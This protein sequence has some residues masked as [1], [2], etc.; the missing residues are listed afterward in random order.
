MSSQSSV[1]NSRRR[2]RRA[3]A[4][5][6]LACLIVPV[7]IRSAAVAEAIPNCGQGQG[8][9]TGPGTCSVGNHVFIDANN[10]GVFETG[11]LGLA[12][13]P[14]HL[15]N[16]NVYTGK[17]TVT[18]AN[19]IYG[20]FDL[21]SSTSY[22]V[23]VDIPTGYRGSNGSGDLTPGQDDTTAPDPNNYLDNDDNG[24]ISSPAGRL[25]SG[26][27]DLSGQINSNGRVDF[28]LY[29]PG[30]T[31]GNHVFI[32]AN[33]SGVYEA[34]EQG[35]ANTPVHLRNNNA[36]TGKS[37]VTNANGIYSFFD[38]SASDSYQVCVDIPT[39]YRGSNGSGSLAPGQDDTTA[40]DPNNYVDNDDNGRISNPAGRL[41]SGYVILSGGVASNGR[42]DFGL[43]IPSTTTTLATTTTAVRSA[44]TTTTT[45]KTSETTT[46]APFTP[47]VIQLVPP[48]IVLTT[49][50]SSPT[51]TAPAPTTTANVTVATKQNVQV[52]G[53][54]VV[55][56]APP[57]EAVETI[58][59]ALTGRNSSMLGLYSAIFL[60]SGLILVALARMNRKQIN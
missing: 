6:F 4:A 47:P 24:R 10:S 11:E 12:N 36:D 22:Q 58:E 33:N 55:D 13:T 52:A 41:C 44:T 23:C 51:T 28:G 57:A 60:T 2:L 18:N 17:S 34:G 20:F 48:T 14:V 3:I 26:Y 29:V 37:T 30:Y 16:N 45:I 56:T 25:C 19:G 32:D 39:G 46:T 9:F 21:N 35:L 1:D 59:P 49:T 43:Y 27:I 8:S 50:T 42:V 53:I 31:V 38:L 40:P 54:Q 15:W 5:G 7:G